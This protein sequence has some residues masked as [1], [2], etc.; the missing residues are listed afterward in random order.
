MKSPITG[1]SMRLVKEPGVKLTFR[2]EEFEI[3]YHAFLCEDS[4]E[5]FTSDEED[6]INQIQVYNKYCEKYGIP[7]PDD[8]KEV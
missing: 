2:K 4:G 1:K 3:T 7:I 6:R 8:N 5:K